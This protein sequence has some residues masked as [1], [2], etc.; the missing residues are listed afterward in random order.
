MKCFADSKED[1]DEKWCIA[2]NKPV[3][4]EQCFVKECEG[5]FILENSFHFRQI[6]AE[7]PEAITIGIY[8]SKTGRS[9]NSFEGR[10]I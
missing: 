6:V 10:P 1:P 8:Q 2:E 5:M 7:V 9:G 3:M 4:E